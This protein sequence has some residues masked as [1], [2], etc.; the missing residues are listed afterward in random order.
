MLVSI[1]LCDRVVATD[2]FQV[3]PIPRRARI[4]DVEAVI[5]T[6]FRTESRQSYAY[7][8]DVRSSR[9][10]GPSVS[11]ERVKM[12]RVFNCVTKLQPTYASRLALLDNRRTHHSQ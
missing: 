2:N 5:R 9:E 12:V 1:L 4:S 3:F 10:G 8:H 6:V 7:A 11:E